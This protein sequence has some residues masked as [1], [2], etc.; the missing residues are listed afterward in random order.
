MTKPRYSEQILSVPLPFDKSKFH[1]IIL[2]LFGLI[3][4]HF[5]VSK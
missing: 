4:I 1:C 5:V 3:S 2:L